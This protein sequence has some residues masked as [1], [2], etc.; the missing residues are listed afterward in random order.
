MQRY[1]ELPPPPTE[2]GGGMLQK[3][4]GQTP[5]HMRP[6]IRG[7]HVTSQRAIGHSSRFNVVGGGSLNAQS[8]AT[9]R[10][11]FGS[12]PKKRPVLTSAHEA[13][14]FWRPG[15]HA[16]ACPRIDSLGQGLRQRSLSYPV[17]PGPRC[18]AHRW[19]GMVDWLPAPC[20]GG[21][22]ACVVY[23][24]RGSQAFGLNL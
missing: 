7:P 9:R 14:K 15:L 23:F 16:L 6:A 10:R 21:M 11:I 24:C 4:W 5:H 3:R 20:T 13:R 2:I 12:R 1:S 17:P 22:A 19:G 18:Q 8:N